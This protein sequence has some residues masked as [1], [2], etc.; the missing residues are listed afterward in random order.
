MSILAI[1]DRI[2]GTIQDISHFIRWNSDFKNAML[3]AVSFF[4]GVIFPVKDVSFV[5]FIQRKHLM[6]TSPYMQFNCD[7][8]SAKIKQSTVLVHHANRQIRSIWSENKWS[9]SAFPISYIPAACLAKIR[10]LCARI[11]CCYTQSRCIRYVWYSHWWYLSACLTRATIAA[12]Q[13]AIWRKSQQWAKVVRF[14]KKLSDRRIWSH[15]SSY[16]W[17]E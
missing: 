17:H 14:C 11:C 5:C 3:D 7:L 4:P 2:I 12:L 8:F 1:K 6:L 15:F 13:H 10:V 9:V 16:C